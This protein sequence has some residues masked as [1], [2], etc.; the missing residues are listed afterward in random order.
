MATLE[1]KIDLVMEYIATDDKKMKS[2]LKK[3]ISEVIQTPVETPPA[4]DD[5]SY[6]LGDMIADVLKEVGVPTHN[7]GY[8][9]LICAIEL[10]VCD[11]EYLDKIS[12]GLYPEVAKRCDSVA[13]R[14]ERA[15]R[16]SI[17][18]VFEGYYGSDDVY[19]IIGNAVS[20]RTGKPTN[21]QFISAC[22][23]EVKRRMRQRG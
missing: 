5:D 15:I 8:K 22:V 6:V 1:Q 2:Q 20:S 7:K 17:C 21:S 23:L 19:K 9:Y 14:V 4:T 11:D 10:C 18:N 13:T 16:H 3:Q 12:Y